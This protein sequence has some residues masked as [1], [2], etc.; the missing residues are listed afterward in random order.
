MYLYKSLNTVLALQSH[1][2][3]LFASDIL[4]MKIIVKFNFN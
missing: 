2:P 1:K 3:S 4:V